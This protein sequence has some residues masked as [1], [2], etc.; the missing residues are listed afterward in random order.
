[1]TSSKFLLWLEKWDRNW[2]GGVD[3]IKYESL[4]NDCDDEITAEKLHHVQ[5]TWSHLQRNSQS[6]KEDGVKWSILKMASF[7]EIL[8]SQVH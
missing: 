4:R 8:Q 6:R 1:M 5:Q 3:S 2:G 7:S